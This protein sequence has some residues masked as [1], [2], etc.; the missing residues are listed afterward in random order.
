MKTLG[1]YIAVLFLSC[2]FAL[3]QAQYKILYSFAGPPDG[4]YPAS[5]V[6][7]DI[8]GNLYGTTESGGSSQCE[9]GCGTVFRLSPNP[10][11]TW[12]ET[13]LYTF[14]T[15]ENCTDGQYPVAG[16]TIDSAG[17][18]YGVT[19]TGAVFEL[20][21][22]VVPADPWTYTLLFQFGLR[23]GGGIDPMGRMIFDDSGNLYGTTYEG[24]T[25][26][27]SVF[28]LSPTPDG[29]TETDLYDFCPHPN[30]NACIDGNGPQAG[31]VFDKAGNL[32]GTTAFGGNSRYF[33]GGTVYRLSHKDGEW[34]E[35]VLY[36]FPSMFSKRGGAPDGAVTFDAS[37][38]L[39]G[40]FSEGGES[41]DGGVFRL[42]RQNGGNEEIVSF[43]GVNGSV[44]SSAVLIDPRNNNLYGTAAGNTPNLHGTI[45]KIAGKKI[46]VLHTFGGY[47]TDGDLPYGG[48]T[49]DGHGHLYGTTK[50]GGPHGPYGFGTVFEIIP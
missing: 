6:I 39:F 3:G 24:G 29:W 31:V 1:L 27:G 4:A 32:Y 47:P 2:A 22:P 30:V 50:I 49:S 11:G 33:G 7:R 40:T 42:S 34:K 25:G 10:D 18:L 44:P 21:P 12:S 41:D 20:S 45:F 43:D 28:E 14:C 35:T 9:E 8:S 48:L 23:F 15:E 13:V 5:E 16:L 36:A 26:W 38:N 37:G 19:L 46:I 17:N